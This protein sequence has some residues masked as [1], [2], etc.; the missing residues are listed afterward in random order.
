MLKEA[1]IIIPVADHED[2][3]YRGFMEATRAHMC[4]CFGGY[5]ETRGSGGWQPPLP[6]NAPVVTEDVYIFDIT[7]DTSG[8]DNLKLQH[9]AERVCARMGQSCVYVR[10]PNG[11]VQFVEVSRDTNPYVSGDDVELD[12]QTATRYKRDRITDDVK[13]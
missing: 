9:I 12:E 2:R 10:W 7:I 3:M 11:E 6:P 5:T 4:K 8:E 13:V 1:R